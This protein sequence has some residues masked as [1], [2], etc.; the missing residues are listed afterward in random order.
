MVSWQHVVRSGFVWHPCTPLRVC[1]LGRL[2]H[3]SVSKAAVGGAVL[4]SLRRTWSLGLGA[5]SIV[6]WCEDLEPEPWAW[7]QATVGRQGECGPLPASP[8]ALLAGFGRRADTPS[9]GH[10]WRPD[11]ALRSSGYKAPTYLSLETRNTYPTSSLLQTSGAG[12]GLAA[13]GRAV[14]RISGSTL[15]LMLGC[16][17]GVS[18]K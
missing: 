1:S 5:F 4:S 7:R 12:Q 11:Q 3:R 8:A 6:G 9:G 15:D 14:L 2:N 17:G 16:G 13:R 18:P 10:G